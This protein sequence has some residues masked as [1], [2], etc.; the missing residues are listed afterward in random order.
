MSEQNKNKCDF[1]FKPAS[2]VQCLS[3][4]ISPKSAVF[5]YLC[6]LFLVVYSYLSSWIVAPCP[7]LYKSRVSNMKPLCHRDHLLIYGW[8]RQNLFWD[9]T[10]SEDPFP[11]P[12]WQ[13]EESSHC[14]VYI[15]HMNKL[16]QQWEKKNGRLRIFLHSQNSGQQTKPLSQSNQ[17]IIVY[18]VTA[19]Q[20]GMV[21]GHVYTC[22]PLQLWN[23]AC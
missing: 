21:T 11:V 10:E 4:F 17:S 14:L 22:N 9:N 7:A 2:I 1:G 15:W 12:I 23:K 18:K 8:L 5:K 3:D 6:K 13:Q 19:F 16:H 20:L